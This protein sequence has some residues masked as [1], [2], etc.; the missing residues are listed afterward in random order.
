VQQL[1]GITLRLNRDT[2]NAQEFPTA[3]LGLRFQIDRRDRS[4]GSDVS[5]WKYQMDANRFL[6]LTSLDTLE[7]R[8]SGGYSRGEIPFY[9]RFYAGGFNFS[10]GAA[11]QLLG[12]GRDEFLARQ[13]GIAGVSYRRQVLARPLGFARR[14]FLT[15]GYNIAALSDQDRSPYRFNRYHGFGM[16]IAIDTVLGPARFTGGWGESSRFNFH[17]SLGPSF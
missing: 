8:L 10:D 5:Y 9:D 12:Y 3:G 2:L 11:R 13:M 4:L 16:G 1:S 14:A 6:P 17:I 15:A 7:I